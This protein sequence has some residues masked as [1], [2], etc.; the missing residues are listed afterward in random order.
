M[1]KLNEKSQIFMPAAAENDNNLAGKTLFLSKSHSTQMVDAIKSQ[2]IVIEGNNESP[3]PTR[4]DIDEIVRV[5]Q[6]QAI[7][8]LPPPSNTSLHSSADLTQQEKA[9]QSTKEL[10]VNHA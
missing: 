1:K 3:G 10:S 4:E 7:G 6:D 8:D 9:I 5:M 2:E